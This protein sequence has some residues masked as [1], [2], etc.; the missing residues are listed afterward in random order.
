MRDN[1]RKMN[2]Y[3]RRY[4]R[5]GIEDSALAELNQ[6]LD[7]LYSDY[8]GTN[9]TKLPQFRKNQDDFNKELE[10]IADDFINNE[11]KL[12]D[13]F[14]DRH[15]DSRYNTFK[16]NHPNASSKQDYIDFIESNREYL[17]NASNAVEFDS[18]QIYEFYRI[19]RERKLTIE[20]INDVINSEILENEGK[21]MTVDILALNIRR[22]LRSLWLN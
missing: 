19:G 22:R 13:I 4:N 20:Q 15:K 9:R 2:N 5:Q 21:G 18:H 16:Q 6:R 11:N 7:F 17:S 8:F 14:S 12:I 10:Q 3:I 1:V